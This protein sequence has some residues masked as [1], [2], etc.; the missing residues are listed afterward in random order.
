MA[1]SS[2]AITPNGNPAANGQVAAPR[3]HPPH[4]QPCSF[5]IDED[6]LTRLIQAVATASKP[7]SQAQST[8]IIN[9]TVSRIK[10]HPNRGG[11]DC[12]YKPIVTSTK[13]KAMAFVMG[14]QRQRL[15]ISGVIVVL[16]IGHSM[17][18]CTHCL[19][20]WG[21]VIKKLLHLLRKFVLIINILFLLS[22][23]K[24]SMDN[25]WLIRVLTSLKNM[26]GCFPM[27]RYMHSQW[28]CSRGQVYTISQWL[29]AK[30]TTSM[31]MLLHS[32]Q[33]S[34]ITACTTSQPRST[35]RLQTLAAYLGVIEGRT[36]MLDRLVSRRMQSLS[37]AKSVCLNPDPNM[38]DAPRRGS[39]SFLQAS[40]VRRRSRK[41][42][43][44]ETRHVA[45]S[46]PPVFTSNTTMNPSTFN[47]FLSLS[48]S[49]YLLIIILSSLSSNGQVASYSFFLRLQ[50]FDVTAKADQSFVR[51]LVLFREGRRVAL[52]SI[53]VC[54]KE[55]FACMNFAER[56]LVILAEYFSEHT[57]N[58]INFQ[59]S[60]PQNRLRVISVGVIAALLKWILVRVSPR[61]QMSL[62]EPQTCKAM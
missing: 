51:L 32:G 20:F 37:N 5:A 16:Y 10:H 40:D 43:A 44:A 23:N 49:S 62:V 13:V 9:L 28:L 57:Q 56:R 7:L 4:K 12:I 35:A 26:V 48:L 34:A 52:A 33:S 39:S 60:I 2:R 30:P 6:M 41:Q 50:I 17:E 11:N 36:Q 46:G 61:I 58:F 29:D 14:L 24:R 22:L 21:G 27:A 47:K 18:I 25:L 38:A 3:D 19:P 1:S 15:Q 59:K 54:R 42:P 53:R 45:F 8:A 55:S 31:T